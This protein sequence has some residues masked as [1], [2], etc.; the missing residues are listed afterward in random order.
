MRKWIIFSTIVG[1]VVITGVAVVVLRRVVIRQSATPPYEVN[2][3][4]SVTT[5]AIPRLSSPRPFSGI[6]I[7]LDSD[8]DGLRDLDELR[9]GR[10]PQRHDFDNE[11]PD[12][13]LDGLSD[14]VEAWFGT[15]P[16]KPDT[17][18]DSTRVDDEFEKLQLGFVNT[19]D[20]DNDGLTDY[21]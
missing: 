1:A 6:S 3:S 20:Q 13:D 4:P 10:N 9:L 19:Q 12:R 2:S 5:G 7:T 18:R 11:G 16:S 8:R 21:A 14:I 15:D 17:N